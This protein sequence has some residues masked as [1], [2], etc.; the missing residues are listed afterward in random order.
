MSFV[1]LLRYLGTL[2]GCLLLQYTTYSVQRPDSKAA[3]LMWSRA[4]AADDDD[5][6]TGLTDRL[7]DPPGLLLHPNHDK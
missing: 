5:P 4:V 3:R 7:H 2:H 1:H 6:R